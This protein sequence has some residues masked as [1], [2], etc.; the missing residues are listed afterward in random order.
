MLPKFT[1]RQLLIG[2]F[3]VAILA[4]GIA[5]AYRGNTIA[6]GLVL[7]PILMVVPFVAFSAIYWISYWIASIFY[8]PIH[9]TESSSF[10]QVA[11]GSKLKE[12]EGRE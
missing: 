3:A 7:A 11:P 8:A 6:Y 12:V 10:I 5:A 9:S 2:T 1:I 4:I